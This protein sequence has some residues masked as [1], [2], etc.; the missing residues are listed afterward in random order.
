MSIVLEKR[1]IRPKRKPY[2]EKAILRSVEGI[3][4]KTATDIRKDYKTITK[5][6]H[7]KVEI[8]T[9]IEVTGKDTTIIVG[10]LDEIFNF[11]DKGTRVRYATMSK[12]F[13]SKT[14]PGRLS[15]TT[16]RGKLM[17]VS[18]RRPRPGIKARNWTPKLQERATR[19]F[20]QYFLAQAQDMFSI[21]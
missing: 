3:A 14:K 19:K 18:K 20:Q 12:D 15:S 21:K 4:R 1:V 9:E 11:L 10:V 2:D 8:E 16:G 6:W 5:P 7:H 17:F 13:S